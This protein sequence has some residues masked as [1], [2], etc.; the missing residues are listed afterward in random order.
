[1]RTCSVFLLLLLAPSLLL[2][3]SYQDF[4]NKHVNQYMSRNDCDTV[5]RNRRISEPDGSC[6]RI[7]TFINAGINQIDQRAMRTCSVFL[8]LL[9]AP[10]LLLG[11]SYQDFRNKHVN[12]Y[13]SRNDCDTVIRNR[14]ISEPDGSCKR[15][16]TFIN[17]GI[18]QIDQV[19]GRAGIPQGGNLRKSTTPFSTIVCRLRSGHLPQL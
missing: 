5:I 1:M 9:L 11:Q 13:M 2:G 16:D 17:A 7:D 3:Q 8:L 19:C 18:N 10:S 15:I 6:K 4:R 14:R 12:Q